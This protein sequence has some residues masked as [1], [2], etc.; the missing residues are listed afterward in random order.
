[1]EDQ[2]TQGNLK[3]DYPRNPRGIR[4]FGSGFL[5]EDPDDLGSDYRSDNSDYDPG[6]TKAL[7]SQNLLSFPPGLMPVVWYRSQQ[8]QLA[9]PRKLEAF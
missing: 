2:S 7:P 4:L 6:D 1:M 3:E 8:D 5:D 9:L